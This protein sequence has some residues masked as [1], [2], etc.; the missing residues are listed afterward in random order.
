MISPP[1]APTHTSTLLAHK[2]TQGDDFLCNRLSAE[3]ALPVMPLLLQEETP[4][5]RYL[6]IAVEAKEKM[7][8]KPLHHAMLITGVFVLEECDGWLGAFPW[9][10]QR[11]SAAETPDPRSFFKRGDIEWRCLTAGSGCGT[12]EPAW[13]RCFKQEFSQEFG[14]LK[15][16]DAYS[17]EIW[18]DFLNHG[19]GVETEQKIADT[20]IHIHLGNDVYAVQHNKKV[21]P[22]G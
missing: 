19:A 15:F 6:V 14:N 8:C 11:P 20:E 22:Q 1:T 4:D 12:I 21:T 13:W 7:T 16:A 2:N 17:W 9:D 18:H 3:C 10:V 5:E